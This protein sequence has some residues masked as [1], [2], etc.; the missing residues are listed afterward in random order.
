MMLLL[1]KLYLFGL[2][3]FFILCKIISL[4]SNFVYLISILNKNLTYSVYN[5]KYCLTYIFQFEVTNERY[6]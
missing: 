4:M 3:I 6:C 5:N 2:S 1:N